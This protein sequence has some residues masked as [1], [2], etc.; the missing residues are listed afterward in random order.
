[1]E[2]LAL[3]GCALR[4]DNLL[5]YVGDLFAADHYYFGIIEAW[6]RPLTVDR[7][8]LSRLETDVKDG[9]IIPFSETVGYLVVLIPWGA[10]RFRRWWVKSN[11]KGRIK[12]DWNQPFSNLFPDPQKVSY[13]GDFYMMYLSSYVTMTNYP[14]VLYNEE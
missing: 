12:G 8:A 13:D 2:V 5:F 14:I 11:N 7:D 3:D 6:E 4:Q 10:T 9:V 1:M